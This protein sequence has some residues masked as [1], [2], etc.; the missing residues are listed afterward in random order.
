MPQLTE[1]EKQQNKIQRL[2]DTLKTMGC[3]KLRSNDAKSENLNFKAHGAFATELATDFVVDCLHKIGFTNVINDKE[4]ND[5][6]HS[7][8]AIIECEYDLTGSY[9]KN[10]NV[11]DIQALYNFLEHVK[12]WTPISTQTDMGQK[13]ISIVQHKQNLLRY[14]NQ[15]KIMCK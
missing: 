5:F 8:H 10:G 15:Q 1:Q 14:L 4:K 7:V 12:S 3:F 9:I 2:C 13:T 6:Y 11:Q